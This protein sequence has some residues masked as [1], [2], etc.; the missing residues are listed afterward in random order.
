MFHKSLPFVALAFLTLAGCGSSQVVT[1][2]SVVT[3]DYTAKYADTHETFK[4]STETLDLSKDTVI[5][6]LKKGLIG[7]KQGDEKTIEISTG[8]G[9]G[10]RYN[11]QMVNPIPMRLF[12]AVNVKPE[13]GKFYTLG[14]IKG[15]VTAISGSGADALVDVDINDPSTYRPLEYDVKVVGFGEQGAVVTTGGEMSNLDR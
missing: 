2:T 10:S 5:A 3:V 13:V 6:G 11:P 4:Q 9:Y 8:E 15:V 1:D 12:I 14:N 7:M